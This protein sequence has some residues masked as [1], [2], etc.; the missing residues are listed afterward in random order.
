[1][2]GAPPVDQNQRASWRPVTWALAG[3]QVRV[4]C[5]ERS[6]CLPPYPS[7]VRIAVGADEKRTV[8]DSLVAHLGE[9]GHEVHLL[10]SLAGGGQEWAEVGALVGS[11]VAEGACELGV[12]LCWSGTGVCIAANKVTGARAALCGDAETAR[13][14][15]RYNHANVLA[16]SLRTTSEAVANEIVEAFVTGVDGTTPFDLRN[17]DA[18]GRVE[19]GLSA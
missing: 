2:V 8:T 3:K 11:Q 9:L 19:R 14:A 15:R 1:M 4:R 13:M 6:H 16:L 7:G 5:V 12:V 10:G 17:L 18:V